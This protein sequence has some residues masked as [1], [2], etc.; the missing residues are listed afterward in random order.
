M[1]RFKL[2]ALEVRA[3]RVGPDGRIEIDGR[4]LVCDV[5]KWVV[6]GTDGGVTVWSEAAFLERFEPADDAARAY[7]ARA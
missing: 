4:E 3:S 7:L 6:I 2:L 1:H 5:G